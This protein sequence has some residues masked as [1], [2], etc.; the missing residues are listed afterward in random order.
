MYVVFT[1]LHINTEGYRDILTALNKHI[2]S[3]YIN[4]GPLHTQVSLPFNCVHIAKKVGNQFSQL[5]ILVG[6]TQHDSPGWS[7]FGSA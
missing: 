5:I 3:G 2:L 6:T 7:C 1:V 4:I